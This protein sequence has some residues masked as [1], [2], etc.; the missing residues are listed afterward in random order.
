MS[1]REA[2]DAVATLR[3]RCCDP[4]RAA[5]A[6]V[7]LYVVLLALPLIVS[8]IVQP[9]RAG[10]QTFLALLADRFGILGFTIV[11]L[12]FVVAA[13]LRWVEWPFG[14]DMLFRFHRSMAIVAGALLVS[15]PLL[16]VL[17]GE[18][19]LVLA[20]A[21]AWPIQLGRLTLVVLLA[22]I[23]TSVF[24]RRLHLRFEQW[25]VSHN[26]LSVTLLVLASTHSLFAGE[27]LSTWPMRA[28]WA[29]FVTGALAAYVHH[30][31]LWHR[32]TQAWYEVS[33]VRQETHDTW[34][35]VL[36]PVGQDHVF[37]YLPGQ[38][39]FITFY[40]AGMPPEEHPFSISSNP[41][42]PREL[43][44]TVKASGDFT[45]TIKHTQPGDRVLVRGPYGRFSH[46]LAPPADR[47]VF[48]AGGVGIT[49]FI[50]M[51]RYMRHAGAWQPTVLLYANKTEDDILFRSELDD[52]VYQSGGQLR[53]VHIVSRASAAWVGE[54]GRL[55]VERLQRY[56]GPVGACRF[57][58]CGP[59]PMMRN[60][61]LMIAECGA[62]VRNIHTE[63]FAL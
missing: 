42:N 20:L 34:T 43:A 11:C 53:V 5:A 63:R 6:R 54:R 46:L 12:Q 59:P 58:V 24:R 8:T 27:D 41:G 1:N 3:D 21:V 56:S 44:S 37:S 60:A 47:L 28:I 61:V 45:Q 18:T 2:F 51:L 55:D 35:L 7:T 39:H 14:L 33:D 48:V 19:D 29:G 17:D 10:P 52:M 38:F 40:R 26:A 50:S 4:S 49:P 25:R 16:M 13:R 15:H 23:A 9:S 57:Y 30:Q 31:F 36:K 62:G 32:R 22:V